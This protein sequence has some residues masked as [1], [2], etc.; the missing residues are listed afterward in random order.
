MLVILMPHVAVS[1]RVPSLGELLPSVGWPHRHHKKNIC[2]DQD[3]RKA[4]LKLL[5]EVPFAGLF[6]DLQGETK[7]E[8]SGLAHVNN[9]YYIVF[10]RFANGLLDQ[11]SYVRHLNSSSDL[12]FGHSA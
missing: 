5:R 4:S 11:R 1:I 6:R 10:D 2:E 9:S 7:F 3:W 8:A 12:S